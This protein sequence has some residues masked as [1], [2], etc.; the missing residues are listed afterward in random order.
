MSDSEE[1]GSAYSGSA[2]GSPAGSGS[3]PGSPAGSVS[4]PGSP[5]GSGGEELS[6]AEEDLPQKRVRKQR[7]VSDEEEDE[8]DYDSEEDED[9]AVDRQAS[10]RKKRKPRAGGFII[11]EADVDDEGDEDDDEEWEDGVDQTMID[12]QSTYGPSAREIDENRR[13]EQMISTQREDEIEEYYRQKYGEGSASARYGE[14]E[15]M[16]DEITQQGLLPGVKDPNLWLVKCRIGEERTTAIQV[17]RKYIAYQ[18]EDEPLQIKAV[19]SKESLKGYIY[20]EAYKQTHVKQ[21]IEGI[22]NLRMGIWAQ[23]MVPIKEMTDV[24]KIVKESAQLKPR[25]WVRLKRGVFKDDLGQVD[26]VEPAQNYV[27]LKLIPRI[28]YTKPRGF[29]KTKDNN[30]AEKRKKKRRPAQKLFDPDAIRG[31]GGE[32]TQDGDFLVFENNRYSRKGFLF[33]NFIMSAIKHRSTIWRE[34]LK[35][36]NPQKYKQYL[37][38]QKEHSKTNRQKLKSI[39]LKKNKTPE[40]EQVCK[41]ILEN[42]RMRQAKLRQRKKEKTETPI[43]VKIGSNKN[44]KSKPSTRK[45]VQTKREKWRVAK[46]KYRANTSN[47]KKRWVKEKDKKS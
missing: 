7:V 44:T 8:D 20:V 29:A 39:R 13:Y 1:E 33:K 18:F 4:G 17:M 38:K 37:E 26:F 34:Q 2:P 19:I 3:P 47:Y 25:S 32:I 9:Y 22:G 12:R 11:E 31:I 46:A 24:M 28:D 30:Q 41:N 14:G 23:Q 42:L 35:K 43:K 6:G 15:E 36:N 45:N 16:S 5:A 21:A 10:K 40:E 27:H